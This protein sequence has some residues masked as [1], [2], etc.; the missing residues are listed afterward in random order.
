MKKF[1]IVILFI[2]ATTFNTV[3]GLD[4]IHSEVKEEVLAK[5][6]TLISQRAI[7]NIGYLNINLIKVERGS[8]NF[9]ILR[10]KNFSNLV[11]LEAA[12]NPDK[13]IIAV[14]NASF[15][16]F[17]GKKGYSL[18]VEIE[19]S[20]FNYAINGYNI[21]SK[22]GANFIY[23][24]ENVL[25]DYLTVNFNYFNSK[26]ESFKI[27]G[28]NTTSLVDEPVIFNNN[29]FH[30]TDD[31]KALG[32]VKLW[33]VEDD[34]IK[35]I[36]TS[37]T[38]IKD[39]QYII[40]V[41]KNRLT[42]FEDKIIVGDKIR[43]ENGLNI[44]IDKVKNAIAGGGVFIRNSKY[45]SEG[46]IV[47]E[48]SRHP[49]TAIGIDE[50]TGTT[51]LIT[52]DGRGT[53]IGVTARELSDILLQHG[54]STAM[55]FDGGGSTVLLKKGYFDSKIKPVNRPSDGKIRLVIN[56]LAVSKKPNPKDGK[57]LI[58]QLPKNVYLGSEIRIKPAILDK[59]DNKIQV[60]TNNFK[61]KLN[62]ESIGETFTADKLGENMI[63]LSYNDLNLKR[64]FTVYEDI[65]DLEVSPKTITTTS[66]ITVK[67]ID[68]YG[69]RHVIPYD[70]LRITSSDDI[71]TF[72]GN[73]F[74]PNGKQGT[75]SIEYRDIIVKAFVL[76]TSST[77]SN[78][79]L[80]DISNIRQKLL[81]NDFS[82]LPKDS[83]QDDGQDKG[84][85]IAIF[86]KTTKP[87]TLYGNIVLSKLNKHLTK[88]RKLFVL[89]GNKKLFSTKIPQMYLPSSFSIEKDDTA[90]FIGLNAKKGRL[91]FKTREEFNKLKTSIENSKSKA[92]VLYSDVNLLYHL[93]KNYGN[94]ETLLHN[95]L[96]DYAINR[97]KTIFYINT[98]AGL[99][100]VNIFEGVRYVNLNGINIW[101]KKYVFSEMYK[102]FY[103]KDTKEG[104]RYGLRK[105]F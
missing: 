68:K 96:S 56:G 5:G 46:L 52:I 7:T 32:D 15:G 102:V 4:I 21:W 105:I 9:K 85:E 84:D 90:T 63:E 18:G 2:F 59:D 86:G 33:F 87:N 37:N 103:I 98:S 91:F 55:H 77:T 22:K 36:I 28:Y 26:N 57:S 19:N 3:Y 104:L 6:V 29:A 92:I 31:I 42:D 11:N 54:V 72:N 13:D 16:S 35:S 8:D 79:V 101:T 53:S 95:L 89:G 76:S 38:E 40:A 66:T 65:I 12:S 64:E 61:I 48:N 1:F 73:E 14:V 74:K 69:Y 83:L 94:S 17:S 75:L 81:L 97:G 82:T 23:N 49:R 41:H 25:F 34:T 58:C 70:K 88:Y 100:S 93:D 44:D 39:N 60:D 43:I 30:Y 27:F 51:Y 45:V 80:K 67:G 24:D 78:A 71:G 47:G 20:K 99:S 50:K 62:G 10:N